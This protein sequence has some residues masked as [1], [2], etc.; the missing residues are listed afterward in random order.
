MP[1]RTAGRRLGIGVT[2][3][4]DKKVAIEF[5]DRNNRIQGTAALLFLKEEDGY[6]KSLGHGQYIISEH[7]QSYL[8]DKG[9]E[10]KI[11]PLPPKFREV[12]PV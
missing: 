6:A 10:F 3:L 7:L 8:K 11:I 9:V 1:R 5:A 12:V 4:D 2:S